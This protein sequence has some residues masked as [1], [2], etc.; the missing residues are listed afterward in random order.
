MV[1]SYVFMGF[2]PLTRGFASFVADG[3]AWTVGR[4]IATLAVAATLQA[5]RSV[6]F[7]L[8]DGPT[9]STALRRRLS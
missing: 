9:S 8:K 2:P 3:A 4:S 7:A 5:Y 1:A 6:A